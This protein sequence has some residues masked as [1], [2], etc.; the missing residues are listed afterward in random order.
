MDPVTGSLPLIKKHILPISVGVQDFPDLLFLQAAVLPDSFKQLSICQFSVL[1]KIRCEK[2]VDQFLSICR[3]QSVHSK[4]CD[5]V[6][7]HGVCEQR[8]RIAE[9]DPFIPSHLRD[10][11]NRPSGLLHGDPVLMG[12][13]GLRVTCSMDPGGRIQLKC[14]HFKLNI[15]ADP[16]FFDCFFQPL[17]PYI[18]V[19]ACII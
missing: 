16:A 15:L 5:P 3:L 11:F 6:R 7:V 12:K 9:I 4:F 8:C 1:R 13:P 14:L 19:R 10:L 17:F 18:A 2:P